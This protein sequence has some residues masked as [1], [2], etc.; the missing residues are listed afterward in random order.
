M[1]HLRLKG[2]HYDIGVKRG[3]LFSKYGI[4][5]PLH[6]DE[7][8]LRHG[9]A[10]EALLQKYFPDVCQEV[11]G[12]T[13]TIGND[14]NEFISWLLAMGCCMYNIKENHPIEIR[15]CTAFAVNCSGQIL[16]G[17]N[18]DLPPYLR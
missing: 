15:D 7:S 5:F 6:M 13:D 12:I 3:T 9:A 11:R 17:R 10:S 16:Y 4:S 1:Y 2:T 18:N 8:Q 14:H